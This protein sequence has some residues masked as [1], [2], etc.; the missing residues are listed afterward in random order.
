MKEKKD[1]KKKKNNEKK[2]KTKNI[3]LTSNE[4]EAL[5]FGPSNQQRQE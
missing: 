2:T 3:C 4:I 5:N 1:K